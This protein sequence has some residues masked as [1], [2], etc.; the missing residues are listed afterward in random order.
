MAKQK[1]EEEDF[2]LDLGIKES[3]SIKLQ[4]ILGDTKLIIKKRGLQLEVSTL[5]KSPALAFAVAS[6][7]IIVALTL[8][9]LVLGFSTFPP[10]VPLTFDNITQKW[11][12]TDKLVVII[13]TLIICAIESVIIN[14]GIR[15]FRFDKRFALA[16]W[17]IIFYINFLFLLAMSQIFLLLT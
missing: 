7:A 12:Q 9:G 11:I 14:L 13:F 3:P 2:Q 1:Q 17:W 8:A 15:A 10:K 4:R 16:L 5:W 6:I